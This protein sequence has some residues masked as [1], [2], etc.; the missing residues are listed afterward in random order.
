MIG[1]DE[2]LNLDPESGRYAHLKKAAGYSLNNGYR[3]EFGVHSGATINFLAATFYQEVWHGFDSFTGL[4]ETWVRS[5]DGTRRSN[6]GE[7]A[8]R[9]LPRV[10]A[11]VELVVGLLEDTLPEWSQENEGPIGFMHIDTDLYSSCA[12]ILRNLNSKIVPGTMIVL[13]ELCDWLDQG[14][15]ERWQEGEWAAL[16]EWIQG[17][18][19]QVRAFSRTDWI[20]GAVIVTR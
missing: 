14:V 12:T 4:P 10:E 3:A 17:Y 11:N 19:R 16:N 1:K 13:D 7:F 8:L 6:K 9:R 2:F 5:Y 20:E 18:D 15:Y